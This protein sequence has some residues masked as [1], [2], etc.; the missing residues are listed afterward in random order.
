MP[1]VE[2]E[3]ATPASERPQTYGLGRWDRVFIVL[4]QQNKP[5]NNP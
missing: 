2:L 3:P 1:T 5:T 4:Q